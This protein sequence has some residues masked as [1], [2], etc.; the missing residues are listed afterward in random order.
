M[1]ID[2]IDYEDKAR[3]AVKTFWNSRLNA[4]AKQEASGKIDQ[5]Q[6]GGVTAGKNMDGFLSMMIDIVRA[7]GLPDV[8]CHV[9][10]KALT[11][12]GYFRPTK[13]W[14]IL[15]M[16]GD[17]LIA[18]LEFKSQVGSFG[19]NFNNRCEESIGTAHDFA[20]SYREGAFGDCSSPFVGWLILVEDHPD[21][22]SPVEDKAPHFPVMSVFNG[23]SYADRYE[24]FCRRLIQEKLYTAASVIMSP[25]SALEDGKYSEMSDMTGLR[26]FVAA[27]AGHAATESAKTRK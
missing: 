3:K 12:P 19:N 17:H 6:R 10:Q 18:A 8:D 26:S 21:S 5:G 9:K 27:L 7:N 13:L 22:R 23:A 4:Q 20:T 2:L 1:T 16:D 15:V 11:L 25:R 14:D 24:V